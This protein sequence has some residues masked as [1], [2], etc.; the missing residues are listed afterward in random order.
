MTTLYIAE[1]PSLGRTISQALGGGRSGKGMISGHGWVVTWCIGH[2]YEQAMPE[3]YDASL[4]RWSRESLPIVPESWKLKP[5]REPQT[6]YLSPHR[7][8]LSGRSATSR[9]TDSDASLISKR[10]CQ[11]G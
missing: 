7:L 8:S 2:L 1:K 4:K 3:D 6:D 5:K 10:F 9:G 11:M